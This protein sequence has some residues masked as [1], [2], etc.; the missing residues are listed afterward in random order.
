MIY[1]YYILLCISENK[2]PRAIY[3]ENYKTKYLRLFTYFPNLITK[4]SYNWWLTRREW[5]FIQKY[6]KQNI[7]MCR[8]Q[9]SGS[10][11]DQVAGENEVCEISQTHKK[12]CEITSQQKADFVELRSW[13]SACSV[14]LPMCQEISGNFRRN[15]T[16][17]CKMAAKSFRNKRVISQLCAKFFLQLGVIG[18]Q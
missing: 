8:S 12:S 14:R 6:L 2:L 1:L 5:K 11:K 17:L 9:I 10:T 15:S 18:L 3:K 7:S 4:E 13:L 16:T